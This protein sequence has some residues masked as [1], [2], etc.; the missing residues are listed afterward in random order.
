M[1]APPRGPTLAVIQ[2]KQDEGMPNAA[3]QGERTLALRDDQ[4]CCDGSFAQPLAGQRISRRRWL[5]LGTLAPLGLC[6]A[7]LLAAK[8]TARAGQVAQ[9]GLFGRARSCVLIFLWG[10]PGQQDLWDLKPQAPS[11]MRSESAPIATR[12]PGVQISEPLPRLA[13][14]ADRYTIIRSMSHRDFE[15]GTAAYTALTGH[16]HPNPG[17]NTPA[18]PDDFP[19]FGAVVSKLK[20]T[21]LAVPDAVV[22]GPIM[23]QGNRPPVAGQNAGFL[24]AAYEPFRVADD[25]SAPGFRVEGFALREDVTAARFARRRNLLA[26]LEARRHPLGPEAQEMGDLYQRAFELLASASTQ[27]AFQVDQEPSSLREAYG[28]G[29]FGQTMLLARRLVETGVPMITVNWSKQNADQWDT[30]KNNYPTLRKLLP[31]LDQ[32][33]A[34]FLA[35]LD[36]RGLLDTTLVVCLG[37]FGRTPRINKDGGR[38][39]WPD[40]YSLLVAGAGV[41]RGRVYGASNRL[42]AYPAR[43]AVAPWD[44]SATIYHLLGIEPGA[45]VHDVQGRPFPVAQGRLIT[46]L[47]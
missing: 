15:H 18:R 41:G 19:T 39:H 31:A 22:L 45:H 7:D 46:G 29:R 42:A 23:Y 1:L 16:P 14:V 38:D 9:D 26:G 30:H 4:R 33:L 20:P 37:E 44:L 27:Q 40:C 47:F 24:G 25:P 36:D 6:W 28:P 2:S 5:E 12:V 43:D 8:E 17:T 10:G 21:S 11:A 34:A 13:Q 3:G 35:D 32:G